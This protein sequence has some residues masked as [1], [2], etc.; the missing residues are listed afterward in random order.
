MAA[1]ESIDDWTQSFAALTKHTAD[2]HH[3]IITRSGSGEMGNV[4]LAQYTS[5][6]CM[7]AP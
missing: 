5:L 7:V 1:D 6:G 4:H 3:K 2:S